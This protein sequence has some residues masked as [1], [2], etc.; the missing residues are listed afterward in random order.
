MYEFHH[1][2]NSLQIYFFIW[3]KKNIFSKEP[4]LLFLVDQSL[5][6]A[7]KEKYN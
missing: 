4:S 2:I 7:E 3:K 6:Q 1:Q 5:K